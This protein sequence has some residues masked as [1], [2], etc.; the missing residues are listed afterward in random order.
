[1]KVRHF[2]ESLNPKYG[3]PTASVPTQCIGV[4]QKGIDVTLTTLEESR[5]FEKR[6]KE[7]GVNIDEYSED[8]SWI[9]K[10]LS[11]T[12][13]NHLKKKNDVDIYHGHGV[14]RPICHWIALSARKNHKKY[15]VNPRGDLE[16]YRIN[17][18]KW[19]KFKKMVAWHLYGKK[20]MQ[21]A[22][23]II[24]TSDQEMNAIRSLGITAP[25]AIIPNGMELSG[26]PSNPSHQP[27]DKKVVLFLSRVNPIKGLEILI[28]AWKELPEH[29]ASNWELHIAGNSDPLDY[30]KSLEAKIK[31]LGLQKEIKLL[32][33]IT[34]EAK[35][36]K[37]Q[38]SDIFILPTYNENFGNVIA[39]AMMC[40]C[41][42]ITTKNA[43]WSYLVEDKCG[44][45]I[46]L[47]KENIL[48]SLKEAMLLSD[49]QR[50][51]LGK[52]SRN[53]IIK[54]FDKD[55]VANMT[56]DVYRWVLGEGEK[57][58]CVYTI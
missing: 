13:K 58:N 26:F 37:Y 5:L 44:W 15:V 33:P 43:P 49:E 14:W 1:M 21:S 31:N 25:I 11:L 56:I 28:E 16:I 54:R 48:S 53:C 4:A 23:C 6:L 22:S 29:L 45:W 39:E 24:A 8:S 50:L 17:Y 46:D 38:D 2:L 7:T 36:R 55:N 9:G 20:D 51:L 19:K 18:N 12:L 41:P 52:K 32:G 35:M 30:I 10:K 3:G 40:E 42:A 47:S 34:G 57:P 27:H